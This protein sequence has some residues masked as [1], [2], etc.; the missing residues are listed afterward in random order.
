MTEARPAAASDPA[1]TE[2]D[3]AHWIGRT[4]TRTDVVSARLREQFAATLGPFLGP[5]AVPPGLFWCLSPDVAAQH[6]LGLDGH[7]RR[8]LFLPDV[9]YERRMWAGGELAFDG[10][11]APGDT[12]EKTSTVESIAFKSGRSGR[13]CFV[14]VRH[15]HRVD[16]R[17]VIDER[18]DIVYRDAAGP[19]PGAAAPAQDPS[20]S[21]GGRDPAEAALPP[22]VP[23]AERRPFETTPTLLFRYSALTFNAHRIHYD[24]PYA[25]AEE[26][27][28]GLVVHGPLLATLMLN[29]VAGRLGRLPAR[30]A[31]RG[32]APLI[33][34][35]PAVVEVAPGEGGALDASVLSAGGTRH[36]AAT[37]T[38]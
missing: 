15:H 35:T 1:P 5:G 24:A 38:R 31:Y 23:E 13:L 2:A 7:P 33:C 21:A 18:Q 9:P 19:G 29:L 17:I 20:A 27:Y 6:D 14:T 30:F 12:V 36:S 4:T 11:F 22:A 34:G 37:A 8:G 32:L 26:G 3:F 10:E 16:G 25:R 28:A